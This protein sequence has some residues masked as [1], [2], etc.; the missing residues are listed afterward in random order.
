MI[1]ISYFRGY[2]IYS[3]SLFLFY[4]S[5]LLLYE[6]SEEKKFMKNYSNSKEII[7]IYFS[8]MKNDSIGFKGYL[9]HVINNTKQIIRIF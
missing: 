9:F 3:H 5:F 1:I 2:S 7:K 6:P 8:C 4:L